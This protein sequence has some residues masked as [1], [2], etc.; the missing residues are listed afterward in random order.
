MC[1]WTLQTAYA[2]GENWR[3]ITEMPNPRYG[4]G[5]CV[6]NGKIYVT[7]GM[8]STESSPGK[9]DF[10]SVAMVNSFDPETGEWDTLAPLNA[11]RCYHQAKVVNGKI[12][13]MGGARSVYEESTATVEVYDAENNTWEYIKEI[14][15]NRFC[16]G[17]CVLEDQIYVIGGVKSYATRN[18][19]LSSVHKF[20]PYTGT[21]E[22]CR[23]MSVPRSFLTADTIN[24]KIYA[25]GGG[26]H[27]IYQEGT[28]EAYDPAGDTW[29]SKTSMSDA[30]NYPCS[31]IVNDRIYVTG[32]IDRTYPPYQSKTEIYN[33]YTDDWITAP[34][35]DFLPVGI[36]DLSCV[37]MNKKMYVFGGCQ[38]APLY[39]AVPD[40]LE[41][42]FPVIRSRSDSQLFQNDS[43][44]VE[45]YEDG[46]L[47]I[48]PEG[49]PADKDSIFTHQLGVQQGVADQMLTIRLD[50]IPPG[51]YEIFG[52]ALD[53]RLDRGSSRIKINDT[54][55][56]IP[57]TAFLNALIDEGVDANMDGKISYAEAEAVTELNVGEDSI[58]DITGIEAFINL[59]TLECYRNKLTSLDV[60]NNTALTNLV[61]WTNNLTS[62][63]VSKNNALTKLFCSNNQLTSLKVSSA[64]Q[65]LNCQANQ[66]TSLDVS[67]CKALIFL[68]CRNNRLTNLDVADIATLR[69]LGC[70]DNQIG[71]LDVS[72]DTALMSLDCSNNFLTNLDVTTNIK[73]EGL[74]G[75]TV[76]DNPG[77]NCSD[78]QLSSL[79][80][81]N[82]TA[83]KS[84]MCSSNQLSNLDISNN[85]KLDFICL[86]AMPSLYQ[87]CVWESFKT[88][89]LNIDLDI[90]GS[91]NV[92]F[93]TDC[94]HPE[95]IDIDT[96]YLP[97]SIKVT[98]SEDGM[99]YLVHEE[100]S[101][102]LRVIRGVCIDSVIAVANDS[103]NIPL[104]EIP[105]GTYW[106]YARDYSGNISEPEA[107]TIMG[108]GIETGD[109][110]DIKI[111]PNPTNTLLTIETGRS[112][113]NH[114]N[115]T[116]LNG[117]LISVLE[118]A[119]PIY[120]LDL[121]S[122]QKGIY[123]LTLRSKDF[124]TT[125]KIVK[126]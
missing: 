102:D 119:G 27:K 51:S 99:I 109:A 78:N 25:I 2:Q 123:F 12:Y 31:G 84:L 114:I 15:E 103:V 10:H 36:S 20:D 117:Q 39:R 120:Q 80:V 22:S 38:E 4:T 124:K 47:F 115:I 70:S 118:F 79:D 28:V 3:K 125:R 40:F 45:F 71:N 19:P 66:L 93:T 107:F 18:D 16:F 100:T 108:V 67:G 98:S 24:G 35:E 55:V 9:A 81:S 58:S 85:D 105:N 52:I 90:T 33:P 57:D 41:F 77:L 104:S 113:K 17:A 26:I 42:D 6:L 94:L 44:L 64:I 89:S 87:V 7:G 73:L 53:G 76:F 11:T 56:S 13:V 21:W 86:K 122:F 37:T 29:V 106:L 14:P 43:L 50:T 126:F 5:S 88:D 46:N 8:Y 1:I 110:K 32:G 61:C 121:S 82:N 62:L 59:Y 48:V 68:K 69:A 34:R 65:N 91:P 75:E 97:D 72:N 112:E 101:K 54:I 96:L 83:L 30:R 74:F 23:D 95:I 49:T 116:S 111:F 63:D 92:Y 60:S